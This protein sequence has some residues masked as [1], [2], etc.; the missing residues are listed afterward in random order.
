MATFV[1]ETYLSR[2]RSAALE[3]MADRLRAAIRGSAGGAA[4]LA[5]GGVAASAS[6]LGV[7][8]DGRVS[9]YLRSFYV[10]DDEIAFHLVE[11]GTPESAA[12]LCR[13]ADIVPER[14]VEAEPALG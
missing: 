13:A 4:D 12:E 5:T 9:R 8:P 3:E 10:A 1:I 2:A 11:S 7:A 14:I 6:A